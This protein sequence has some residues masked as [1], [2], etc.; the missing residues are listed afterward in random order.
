M[1]EETGLQTITDTRPLA[2]ALS[3]IRIPAADGDVGL[4]F[5]FYVCT[6][7]DASSISLSDEHTDFGWFEPRQAAELLTNYP[8]ELVE[9]IAQLD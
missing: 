9:K 8:A 7:E 5:A 6:L 2:M 4:I 3:G 1:H